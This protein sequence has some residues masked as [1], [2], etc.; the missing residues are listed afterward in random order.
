[1]EILLTLLIPT[2][3]A[4]VIVGYVLW[5]RQTRLSREICTMVHRLSRGP[6][7]LASIANRLLNAEEGWT[8][9]CHGDSLTQLDVPLN[10]EMS[11]FVSV[12][13]LLHRLTELDNPETP[14]VAQ[15]VMSCIYQLRYALGADESFSKGCLE[16]LEDHLRDH[17]RA[18]CEGATFEPVYPGD[19][20]DLDT[21]YLVNSH[22]GRVAGVF[23]AIIR[24][25][26]GRV[27]VPA[28]VVCE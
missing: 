15:E 22:G 18:L 26:D 5:R 24:A 20:L 3:L 21:M 25:K 1:M 14:Q 2:L 19:Q 8:W 11:S 12:A 7:F 13:D 27:I 28:R 9:R 17:G 6:A 10:Q 4:Q 23:G 16:S